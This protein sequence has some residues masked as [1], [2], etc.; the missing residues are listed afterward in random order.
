LEEDTDDG[1]RIGERRSE[2]FRTRWLPRLRPLP[3]AAALVRRLR[4]DGKRLA[5]ATSAK[6]EEVK[7]LLRVAGVDGL[8]ESAT[9]SDDAERSKPD[10][11]VVCA[12]LARTRCPPEDVLMLGDTPYD[13]EAAGRAGVGV[14]AFRSGGWDDRAL[15]GARAIYDHPADL[16]DHYADSPLAV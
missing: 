9:T 14:I 1:R 12:A 2:I 10:P 15:G 6:A 7:G 11:D 16:L 3:G 5:V 4:D 13:I 8:I